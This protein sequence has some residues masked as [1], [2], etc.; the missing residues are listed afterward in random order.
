MKYNLKTLKRVTNRI[1]ESA[2]NARETFGNVAINWADFQCICAEY[3]IDDCGNTGY[4]VY[5]EE[6]NPDNS[7]VKNFI[8]EELAMLGYKEVE[9]VF[10]W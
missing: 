3:Y 4:R 2:I 1:C 9:I 7:E 6:A 5:I 8:S 10:E